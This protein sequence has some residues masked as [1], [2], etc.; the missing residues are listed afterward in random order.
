MEMNSD[1]KIRY[2]RQVRL[3]GKATQQQLQLTEVRVTGVASAAAEVAKNLVLAGVR[4]VVLDDE[5]AV[6]LNDL[7]TSFLL[8]GSAIGEKRGDAS[9]RR[10]QSLNPYVA[11]SLAHDVREE[12]A[13]SSGTLFRVFVVSIRNLNDALRLVS[14]PRHARADLLIFMADF[15]HL[16]MAFLLSGRRGLSYEE[17]LGSLIASNTALRPAVF[18]RS[19]LLMRMAECP[20]EMPFF[21]RLIYAREIIDRHELSQLSRADVELAAGVLPHRGVGTAIEA[22][23]NG[24]IVAQLIIREVGC[25]KGDAEDGGYAWVA[26]DNSR[27]TEIQVGYLHPT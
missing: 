5:A 24:G 20:A 1:E 16:T 10:L 18:Q 27:G 8:Q 2:D 26:C 14:T 7:K 15:G 3:W 13:L 4:S 11:V 19:L 22:T 6:G 21:E 17:Q 23:L 12:E 9:A 25:G